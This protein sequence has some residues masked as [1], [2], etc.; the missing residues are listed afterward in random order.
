MIRT[1]IWFASFWVYLIFTLLPL[2]KVKK[3]DKQNRIKERDDLVFKTA[4]KWAKSLVNLT[5]TKINII[6]EENLP[7]NETVVFV[8]NHQSN[9]DIPILLGFLN[10]PKAFIAKIE[11]ANFPIVSTWMKYM[12]C[13]FMDRKDIRQSL[14][15]I[16]QGVEYLKKGYSMVIFPE[17]TRSMDGQ[18]GDF[19]P[20]GLKLASKSGVTIIPI[21]IN[22][23][24]NI[25][26]KNSF[27]IKPANVNVIISPPVY[28]ET[29][30][31]TGKLTETIRDIIKGNLEWR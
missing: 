16:N 2:I 3:L 26:S 17:G 9:F 14:H 25:M 15:S 6:G 1:I 5:G 28:P 8:S 13:V 31:D 20:G 12:N 30:K 11:M 19:K 21:T 4:R 23:S 27:I 7:K 24:K 22:G 18:L 10:H 29:I